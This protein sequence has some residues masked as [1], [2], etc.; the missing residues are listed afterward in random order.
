MS[1]ENN[2]IPNMDKTN[3]KDL[4]KVVKEKIK[5][6]NY[7]WDSKEEENLFWKYCGLECKND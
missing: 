4:K 2:M 1:G 7:K 3:K 5:K 6:G